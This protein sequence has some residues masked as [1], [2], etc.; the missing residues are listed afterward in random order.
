M[1]A[2]LVLPDVLIIAL[3]IWGEARGEPHEAKLAVASVIY[4]RAQLVPMPPK[5]PLS[6]NPAALRLAGVCLSPN[7]FSFW[8]SGTEFDKLTRLCLASGTNTAEALAWHDCYTIAAQLCS[9]LF[10]PT[11]AW[12]H[13]HREG[14]FPAWAHTLRNPVTIG[15]QVFW[16][17]K[18]A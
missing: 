18:A 2:T 7:Q 11:G 13:Y 3:T 15:R 1:S 12:T 17:P 4:N 5:G 16:Q 14:L 10:C 8:N 6:D 9:G